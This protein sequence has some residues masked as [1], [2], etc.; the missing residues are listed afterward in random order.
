M[1]LMLGLPAHGG[2]VHFTHARGLADF[3]T[4]AGRHNFPID[5]FWLANESLIT[6]AATPVLLISWPLTAPI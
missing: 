5:A 4:I 3:A 6:R 2:L 1:R